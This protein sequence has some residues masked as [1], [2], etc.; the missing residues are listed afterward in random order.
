[1]ADRVFPSAKPPPSNPPT[2]PAT[3]GQLYN[4]TR[5]A[6]RPTPPKP[7]S[8]RRR[9]RCCLCCC[10]LTLLLLALILLA[11]ITAGVLWF[12]YRPERPS[13]SVSSFQF[14]TFN[15]SGSSPSSS[16]KLNA[17]I[18]VSLI[19][20]NP[21]KKLVF[22]YDPI[23]V[24]VSSAGADLADGSFPAF[25]HGTKNT[26][27]LKSTVGSGGAREV[28]PGPAAALRS[29]L[30]RRSSL[31]LVVELQTKVKVKVGG[32]KT[33]RVGIRVTCDGI[34]APVPKGRAKAA[35]VSGSDAKCKVKLRF[36]IWKW[37]I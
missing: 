13:F 23:S 16:A 8:R 17:L 10:W 21:N 2:F 20:R 11:A 31:P 28:E 18:N 15:L 6:Y 4:A 9:N 19:A 14:S 24:A 36:K 27:A 1:M 22:Y 26:T 25:T 32:L 30:R 7:P 29:D 5:P 3:K 34:T 33:K 12:L 35:S 37:Q